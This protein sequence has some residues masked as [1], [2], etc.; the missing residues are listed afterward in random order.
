MLKQL[1]QWKGFDGQPANRTVYFNL[2]RYE[3][4]HDMELETLEQRFKS[5]Q[6]NVIEGDDRPMTPPEIREMLDIFKVLIKHAFGVR[7][8]DGKRFSKNEGVWDE[9]VDT[10]CFDAFIFYM[11]EDAARANAFM[12]GIW[13]EEMQEAA[14]KI[15]AERPEVH[16]VP[17]IQ[18]AD[19]AAGDQ[20]IRDDMGLTADAP[21]DD[22]PSITSIDAKKEKEFWEYTNDE[23]LEMDSSSWD[24]LVNKSKQGNNVPAQLLVI[25]QQRKNRS[26]A[27]E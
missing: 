8:Q 14:A 18:E 26:P 3:I 4:A 12:T 11:F 6:E 9:F 10:G 1:V 21:D 16:A 19:G 20:S 24:S 22:I 5:F 2:T 25:G 27:D 17:D 7:S 23:L 15:R 13:P